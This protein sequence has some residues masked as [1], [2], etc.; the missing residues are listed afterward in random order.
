MHLFSN[1][2]PQAN[3]W[4]ALDDRATEGRWVISA[5]PEVGT[6]LNIGNYN[7]NPQPNTYRNWAGGEPN[8]WG[9]NE[10]AAVT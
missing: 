3:I 5:G 6:L 4:F 8:D 10:D 1:N 7:A 2:V 9:G